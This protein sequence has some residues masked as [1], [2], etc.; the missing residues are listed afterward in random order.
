MAS[1]RTPIGFL[2]TPDDAG[3]VPVAYAVQMG[4]GR[5]FVW[6]DEWIQFDSEWSTMPEIRQ[7]WIQVFAWISP[8]GNCGL[9]PPQ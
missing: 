4:S 2:P 7:L 3:V 1:T 8:M 9:Q 5:A 6:D